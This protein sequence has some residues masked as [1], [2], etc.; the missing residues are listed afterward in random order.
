MV[1]TKLGGSGP[2]FSKLCDF[3]PTPPNKDGKSYHVISCRDFLIHT[4]VKSEHKTYFGIKYC[5]RKNCKQS[6]NDS[7]NINT[8]CKCKTHPG[9][10]PPCPKLA[11]NRVCPIWKFICQIDDGK[12]SKVIKDKLKPNILRHLWNYDHFEYFNKKQPVCI[13]GNKCNH[14][15]NVLNGSS[16]DDIHFEDKIHLHLY[17]HEPSAE[18]RIM[19]TDMDMEQINN[20]NDGIFEYRP[21]AYQIKATILSSFDNII[22]C[23]TPNY[24]L[25]LLIQEV[26]QNGFIQ[27]LKP[28]G[29]NNDQ[30]AELKSDASNLSHVHHVDFAISVCKKQFAIFDDLE[31]AMKHK[32]YE[33]CP[34]DV[35][36]AYILALLLYCNGK[37]NRYLC[38]SQRDR[39]YH[40]KWRYFDTFLNQAIR[41]LSGDEV[42]FENLY[43]G[44]CNVRL[45]IKKLCLDAQGIMMFKTNVSFSSNVN[46]AKEFRGAEGMILGLNMSRDFWYN[47]D[48][49]FCAC[50]VSWL[51]KYPTEREVLVA[52]DSIFRIVP[53][54]SI[55]IGKNQYVVLHCGDDNRNSF[56][57][58]FLM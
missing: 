26:I 57:K 42:H 19:T 47:Y 3:D 53:S 36:P 29:N 18:E 5:G 21:Y 52:R 40:L 23:Y 39:T 33:K 16:S 45:D 51:S 54:Q 32:R 20:Q 43:S 17:F 46:V 1:S 41:A 55:Q 13:D 22:R 4:S 50:D 38:E 10:T 27:D 37:C 35:P 34:F 24:Q 8:C 12:S 7:C 15:L 58:M 14:Y 28:K 9:A 49:R 48:A 2:L 11:E 25:Y 44:L 6:N 31:E 30:M 56:Q